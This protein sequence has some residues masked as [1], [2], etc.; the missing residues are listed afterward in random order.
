MLIFYLSLIDEE[1]KKSKFEEL[2][3]AYRKQMFLVAKSVVRNDSDAEDVVH[4]VFLNIAIR[5]MDTICVITEEKT[6][7][8]YLL[9]ATKRTAINWLR[10]YKNII[11]AEPE[12]EIDYMMPE[13]PDDSFIDYICNHLEYEQVLKSIDTLEEKYKLVIYYH[14]V[15]EIPVPKV[16]EM[17]RQSVA[18]T[19]KQ[20]VRGKKKLLALLEKKGEL[21][22]VND[23]RRI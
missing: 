17:L 20:L 14:Y 9:T 16:A 6:L 19:K 5:H 12:M 8:N 7:R 13:I 3:L 18:T 22:Y 11:Y 4:E 21:G 23:E 2:Y 1:N 10:R 15:L